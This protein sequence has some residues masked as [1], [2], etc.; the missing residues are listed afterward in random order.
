MA[1]SNYI[2]AINASQS[3]YNKAIQGKANRVKSSNI[4]DKKYFNAHFMQALKH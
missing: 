4:A 1:I 2:E 3:T